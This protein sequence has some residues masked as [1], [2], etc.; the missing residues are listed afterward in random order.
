MQETIASLEAKRVGENE[1]AHYLSGDHE[2]I[3]EPGR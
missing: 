1:G 3:K 2:R